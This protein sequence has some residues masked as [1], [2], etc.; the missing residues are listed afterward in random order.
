MANEKKWTIW[1]LSL[2]WKNMFQWKY[3]WLND[4][5]AH[6]NAFNNI[7]SQMDLSNL[8]MMETSI[9]LTFFHLAQKNK[10]VWVSWT[11]VIDLV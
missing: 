7:Y 8:N 10:L 2:K 1:N 5:L 3:L 9:N 6:I 11:R 4:Q